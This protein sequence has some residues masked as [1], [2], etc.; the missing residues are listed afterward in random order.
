MLDMTSTSPDFPAYT[1]KYGP[2]YKQIQNK[3]NK[4]FSDNKI[5][6]KGG[7]YME[8]STILAICIFCSVIV[9]R[10]I[11]QNPVAIL[12][13]AAIAGLLTGFLAT[14]GHESTHNALSEK[15]WVNT[16]MNTTLDLIGFSTKNYRNKHSV[17]HNFTNVS[18]TD[19]DLD[20]GS[21]IR[22]DAAQSKYWFHKFQ[23][24]YFPFLYS[25]SGIHLLFNPHNFTS[26]A[27]F[28]SWLLKMTPHLVFFLILP[29]LSHGIFLGLVSYGIFLVLGGLYVSLLNQPMHF[30]LD[31]KIY[32]PKNK[33]INKEF[34]LLMI[35]STTSFYPQDRLT[36]FLTVG[37]N[38]H[39]IHSLFPNIS[40]IHYPQLYSIVIEE[41]K[42]EN[43]VVNQ[44]NSWRELFKSH[45]LYLR[46]MGA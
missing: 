22:T 21:L 19:P 39:L 14:L 1:K 42:L 31:S 17:H 23:H 29:I 38:N 18:K 6:K 45:I 36:N 25:V 27:K 11:L 26:F 20:L 12:I 32:L 41:L 8:Y 28:N 2:V 46:Q 37:V 16:V 3:V 40:S 44:Y 43:I 5:S 10:L 34:A 7:V 24:L 35:D 9:F 30:F 4:Y 13:F 33:S 15:K